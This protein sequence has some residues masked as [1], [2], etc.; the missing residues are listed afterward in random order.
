[1]DNKEFDDL[2]G[3]KLRPEQSFD[4]RELDWKDLSQKLDNQD[5]KKRVVP[6]WFWKSMG[7]I[8]TIAII[9]FL[10]N[11]LEQTKKIVKDLELNVNEK[12][13]TIRDTIYQE[14]TI[15]EYD[16]IRKTILVEQLEKRQSLLKVGLKKTKDEISDIFIKNAGQGKDLII[17]KGQEACNCDEEKSKNVEN[18][19][20]RITDKKMVK[21]NLSGQT[22]TIPR[23]DFYN[24]INI[25]SQNKSLL[26]Q[27]RRLLVLP[28][29]QIL[30]VTKIR[31]KE[32]PKKFSI[33]LL[34]AWH[35]PEKQTIPGYTPDGFFNQNGNELGMRI[36]FMLNNNWTLTGEVTHQKINFQTNN[37]SLIQDLLI[38]EELPSGIDTLNVD[39]TNNNYAIGLKYF[40]RKHRKLQP[41][42]NIRLQASSSLKQNISGSIPGGVYTE[43]EGYE[44]TE[45]KSDIQVQSIETGLGFQYHLTSAI[46]W[47]IEGNYYFYLHKKEDRFRSNVAFKSSLL[48]HF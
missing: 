7:A 41:Y 18:P 36:E 48:Y 22:P 30:P 15:T 26:P 5:R 37:S 2:M 19:L 32:G 23:I 42:T 39:Q 3:D 11:E 47:Q 9:F 1:M 17:S 8:A 28:D 10:Y 34:G 20:Q 12:N 38:V 45:K 40:L 4:F 29:Y 46:S 16:T 13:L 6:F 27:K 44:A 31:K 43:P 21:E 14:I 24:Q 35:L 33:G 25:Q